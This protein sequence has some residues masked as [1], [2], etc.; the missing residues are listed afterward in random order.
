MRVLAALAVLILA[1]GAALAQAPAPPPAPA[2]AAPEVKRFPANDPAAVREK[3]L[4]NLH[5]R[6]LT[7]ESVAETQEVEALGGAESYQRRAAAIQALDP[8]GLARN[9]VRSFEGF[10][11]VSLMLDVMR[12]IFPD[13][14]AFK[15]QVERARNL[16]HLADGT[17]T[18]L[19]PFVA[20]VVH[21]A[22]LRLT[23]RELARRA[24]PS[25][26]VSDYGATVAGDCPFPAGPLL[27]VQRGPILEGTRGGR[28]LL[29][30]AIGQRELQAVAIEQ[31]F[32][33]ITGGPQGMSIEVPDRPSELYAAPL[34]G[35]T[36]TFSGSVHKACTITLT[37]RR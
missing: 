36:L 14:E 19:P 6:L 5:D 4:F 28:L 24:Q 15:A 35:P 10:M 34:A 31:R 11:S 23:G 9:Y 37:R 33:K 7:T 25:G 20:V 1:A 3:V 8:D 13:P 18:S 22:A 32:V 26:S 2:P 29:A 30:G 16:I 27:L 17:T 21:R 12:G